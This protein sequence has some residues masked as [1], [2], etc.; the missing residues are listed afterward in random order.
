METAAYSGKV[1]Q[2]N[3][4]FHSNVPRISNTSLNEVIQNSFLKIHQST[5]HSKKSLKIKGLG[6]SNVRNEITNH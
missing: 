5:R 4:F 6:V 1:Q 3:L 2:W